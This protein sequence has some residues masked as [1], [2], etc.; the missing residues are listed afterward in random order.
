MDSV[1]V[2]QASGAN[3]TWNALELSPGYWFLK[4]PSKQPLYTI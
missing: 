4:K 3:A 1:S 2:S